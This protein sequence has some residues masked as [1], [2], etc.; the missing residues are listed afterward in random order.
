MVR[1]AGLFIFGWILVLAGGLCA[2]LVQ[3]DGG[4]RVRPVT[5]LAQSGV[6]YAGMLYVPP[7]ALVGR[8]APAVLAAHGFINTREMQS[9]FAIE[10]ARRGFV[11]LAMDMAGHGYSE[12]SVGQ[13]GF[14][15]P[16]SLAFLRSLPFV[17]KSQVGLEGHSMGGVPILKAALAY[18]DGYRSMV[19]E[20]SAPGFLGSAAGSPTFP[21][22]LLVVMGAYDEFAPLM[23]Q[24]PKGSMVGASPRM[25]TLFATQSP[26]RVGVLY[27]DLAA[28][29][30]RRLLV[31]AV[32]H[33]QEHFS[34][35]GVGAAVDWFQ[36]T[37][38]GAA[39][40]KPPGDQIWFRKDL[41]TLAAFIG[42]IAVILGTFRLLLDFGPASLRVLRPSGAEV[43]SVRWWT[44]F[45]ATAAVPAL[46]FY[47]V[48]SVASLI[49]FA[50]FVLTRTLPL[51]LRTFSEQITNQ[52]A[53]WALV[54][55]LCSLLIGRMIRRRPAS[56]ARHW[57]FAF[58]SAVLS[59][60]AGYLALIV[61]DR[62]FDVDA[63][64][65][66]LGLKSL[67]E[68]HA[69]LFLI[70]VVPF[71]A[72]FIMALRSFC[73]SLPV[74]GESTPAALITGASAFCLGFVALLAAQYVSMATRG[75]LLTPDQPLNTIIAFQIAPLLAVI[76]VIA[77]YT[78]R[79]TN[80]YLPGA[81]I[82]GLL[83]T[84]CIVAGTAVFAPALTPLAAP[85]QRSA[86]AAG[87]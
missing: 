20:G 10:L 29:T 13:D 38:S 15:G 54:N 86:P 42:C 3:S 77:A 40:P 72:F 44:A 70:Y 27:G 30:A 61:L 41:A 69:R 1:R 57:S 26:V 46:I 31:P 43:R 83:V 9:P 68:R 24:E 60:G 65:W 18:P 53:V 67:D 35:Q 37:L 22:N 39:S 58:G 33:P 75:L 71:T 59:V 2:N 64:F 76:G 73:S 66:V 55:G 48:M 62:V 11:V 8:P 34:N 49:F 23:W 56:F 14:G 84:W 52:L 17:D 16:A 51:G 4:V 78:F 79:K 63:R 45:A 85:A 7:T 47:P 87:A 74:R 36:R 6:Q 5:Y 81:L 50:P 80:D 28:G 82:C 19:L 12:G 32:D 21:R 25:M